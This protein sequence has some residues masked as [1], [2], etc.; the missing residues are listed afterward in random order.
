VDVFQPNSTRHTLY[1]GVNQKRGVYNVI[2]FYIF[3]RYR[4]RCGQA[5][6]AFGLHPKDRGFESQDCLIKSGFFSGVFNIPHTPPL[7]TD[8]R[9]FHLNPLFFTIPHPV[10]LPVWLA[11]EVTGKP[12]WFRRKCFFFLN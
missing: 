7:S 12:T 5:R 9:P 1:G 4:K 2:K 10:S 6:S 3:E 8:K 11:Q